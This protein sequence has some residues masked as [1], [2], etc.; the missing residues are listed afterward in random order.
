MSTIPLT[1]DEKLSCYTVIGGKER[2]NSTGLSAIL[3]NRG[4][5]YARRNLFYDLEKAGFDTVVSVE[6]KPFHYDIEELS[7]RFPFV[8]FM[9]LHQ[10]Y[11]MGEQI[12]MAVYEIDTPLFFVIWNDMKFITGGNAEKLAKRLTYAPGNAQTIKRLCTV[13]AIQN[14]RF[15]TLPTIQAPALQRKKI[16]TRLLSHKG[17]GLPSI[18][19]FD[20][21]GIYDRE[22]FRKIEFD[23][24]Y[25]N[26]YWQLMDFGFRSYL[27]GEKIA[28]TQVLKLLYEDK[29]PSEDSTIDTDYSRFYL[30]NIAPLYRQ[31]NACLPMRRFPGYYF[32]TKSKIAAA[33]NDFKIS[34]DWVN[35]NSSRWKSAPQTIIGLWKPSAI[36]ELP[37]EL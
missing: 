31:N 7:N 11:N 17:E 12:N 9:L 14:A 16:I 30:R 26:R 5:R 20:G 10:S 4:G 25:N 29:V 35:E 6:P 1:S 2:L 36:E 15:E 33:W 23:G 21:V 28:G 32:K 37:L 3:L 27:W 18:Y 8:R 13:P 19:P 22:K 34:R 24:S